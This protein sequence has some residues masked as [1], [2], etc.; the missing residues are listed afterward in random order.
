MA[1]LERAGD[2]NPLLLAQH[3]ARYKFAAQFIE[4]KTTLDLGC[5][6]AFGAKLLLDEGIP[7]AA[8][9]IS[10][11]AV[12][13]ARSRSVKRVVRA[14]ARYIP[15]RSNTFDAILS[16]EVFEHI[17]DVEKYIAEAFRI[18]KKDG[19]FFLSTPNIDFYPLAGMNPFHV[20]EYRYDEVIELIE[21]A[22]FRLRSCYAQE[23]SGK[24][25]SRINQSSLLLSIMKLKRRVGFHGD[26]L[27]PKLQ[28]LFRRAISG[29]GDE[30]FSM[31]DFTFVK[32]KIDSAELI[33]E[34]EAIK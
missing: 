26:V 4:G 29:G 9:D 30:V 32:G 31:N 23:T 25:A 19:L 34:L 6:E 1:T 28:R 10:K 22:G 3:L 20:K 8:L 24:T 18:L 12:G 27:P 13:M 11:D 17:T 5:G 2:T 7:L 16:F 15:Y 33:Y 14:D 21:K